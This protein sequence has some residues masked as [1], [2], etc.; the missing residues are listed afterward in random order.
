MG[1]TSSSSSSSSS[2]RYQSTRVGLCRVL[3]TLRV[4]MMVAGLAMCIVS[5][6][7]TRG[8]L[9]LVDNGYEG[10]VV[11]ITDQIPQEH[12][13]HVIHGLKVSKSNVVSSER[14]V[15]MLSVFWESR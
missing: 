7:G 1:P 8:D 9:R 4:W 5:A 2:I 11:E 6:R 10:L 12:C 13:N 15:C 14:V 3:V